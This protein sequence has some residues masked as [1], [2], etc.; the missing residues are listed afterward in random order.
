MSGALVEEEKVLLASGALIEEERVL[1]G[2]DMLDEVGRM[3]LSSVA[4]VG[5]WCSLDPFS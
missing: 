4:L 3:V 5:S 1:I 2:S